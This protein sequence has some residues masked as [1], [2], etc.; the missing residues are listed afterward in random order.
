M[1]SKNSFEKSK[2]AVIDACD[3]ILKLWFFIH[4]DKSQSI[5]VQKI[6][7]LQKLYLGFTLD[8]IS[9]SVSLTDLKQ[10]KIKTLMVEILQ[11]KKLEIRQEAKTLDIFE[12]PLSAIKFRRLFFIYENVKMRF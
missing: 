3:L 12:T 5:P 1:L 11:G 6:E 8:S 7:Y 2:D 4:L 10:Q 9:M